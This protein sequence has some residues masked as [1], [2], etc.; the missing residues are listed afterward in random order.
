MESSSLRTNNMATKNIFEQVQKF[1]LINVFSSYEQA[2]PIYVSQNNVLP[3]STTK[4]HKFENPPIKVEII[5]NKCI[6]HEILSDNF[7]HSDPLEGIIIFILYNI[8]VSANLN[9]P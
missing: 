8:L 6:L 5:P 9:R 3:P 2:F 1:S 4:S 7:S